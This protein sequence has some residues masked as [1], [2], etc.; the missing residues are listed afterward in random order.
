[1]LST[2][3]RTIA[4]HALFHSGEKVIVAVS[5]GPDSM[6]LLHALWE[7]RERLGLTLEVAA[8]DHGLRPEAAREVELVGERAAALGLPFFPLSA[9]VAGERRRGGA[10]WQDAARRARLGV[11]GALAIDHAAARVALGHQA[12]DQAET[13]LQ[14]IIRGTGLLGLRGIPYARAPFVRPLLDVRRR[15]VLRYLARRSIPFVDDPSNADPRFERARLRHRL[16]PELAKENPR[17]VE[18]LIGLSAAARAGAPPT[19]DGDP[20]ASVSRRAIAVVDRLKSRGGS[21]AVDVAGGRRVEVSYGRVR[22]GRRSSPAAVEPTAPG[23]AKGAPLVVAR[24]GR[25]PWSAGSAVEIRLGGSPEGPGE[26][27]FDADRV[28]WPLVIRERRAGDRMRP[29]GGRGSRKLSDLM[30]DAKIARRA[31]A[32]LPVLAAADGEVLYVPGLRPAEAGRPTASTRRLLHVRFHP[33]LA[34]SR[35]DRDEDV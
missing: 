6:A 11:L 1:M 19:G 18:A 13:V 20:L 23:G 26:P 9:D 5:G 35:A 7:L 34:V 8:V 22:L 4:G 28:A 24:H 25:Y 10:S 14:R 21:G 12:D 30:I 27:D 16:L 17:V 2:I 31:R 15:E 32:G 33:P 29:R 3:L